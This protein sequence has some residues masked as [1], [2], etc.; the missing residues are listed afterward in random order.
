V[1][2]D[3]YVYHGKEYGCEYMLLLPSQTRLNVLW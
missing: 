2:R 1:T 3:T